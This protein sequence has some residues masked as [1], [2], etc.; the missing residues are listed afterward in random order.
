[1]FTKLHCVVSDT[2]SFAEAG[3]VLGEEVLLLNEELKPFQHDS[4][5]QLS[6]MGCEGDWSVAAYHSPWLVGLGDWYND[7][8]FPGLGDCPFPPALVKECQKH[9][10]VGAWKL[11]QKR[12]GDPVT[13]RG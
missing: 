7:G 13:S 5:L 9:F 6:E 2:S 10:Q 12:V 8:V 4:L 3:L 1:M 11:H